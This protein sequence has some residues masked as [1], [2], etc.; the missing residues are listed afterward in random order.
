M[1][2]RICFVVGNLRR[3][4]KWKISSTSWNWT[5]LGQLYRDITFFD[6]WANY[7]KRD[8]CWKKCLLLFES[9]M[10]WP[11]SE[12]YV[13]VHLFRF[14]EDVRIYFHQKLE[15]FV[16]VA[17]SQPKFIYYMGSLPFLKS[18]APILWLILGTIHFNFLAIQITNQTYFALP[19]RRQD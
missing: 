1:R 19:S 16:S 2:F 18:R 13:D 8:C 6:L 14:N 7:L 11:C 10:N 17:H 15:K 9:L 3:C 12:K 4:L 5:V